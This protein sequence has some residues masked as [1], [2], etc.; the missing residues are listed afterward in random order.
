MN[1][2]RQRLLLLYNLLFLFGLC[3]SP[4]IAQSAQ[5][6]HPSAILEIDSNTKGFL[7]P[8]MT[9][10]ERNAISDPAPGLIIFNYTTQRINFF[11]GDIWKQ[12]DRQTQTLEEGSQNISVTVSFTYAN[13][14]NYMVNSPAYDAIEVV[15]TNVGEV[16]LAAYPA[17]S[18]ITLSGVTNGV[19]ITA[20]IGGGEVNP[21][22]SMTLTYTLTGTPT[23][24]GTLTADYTKD[25]G[26]AINHI[27]VDPQENITHNGQTYLSVRTQ[28]G[29]TWLDRNLGAANVGDVGDYYQWGRATDGHEKSDSGITTTLATS[30]TPGHDDFISS[31]GDWRNPLNADLWQGVDGTNNPCPSGYRLPT[32]TDWETEYNSWPSRST[33]N[34]KASALNL[35]IT[36]NRRG[37]DGNIINNNN[38]FFYWSSEVGK[39]IRKGVHAPYNVSYW[40]VAMAKTEGIPVRCIKD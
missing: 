3:S 32:R 24:S 39:V 29:Q 28:P 10:A 6:T 17:I 33:A 5:K 13:K 8:R 12:I 11:A 40:T 36:G 14:A 35:D 30:D 23:T 25:W 26:S 16:A 22:N 7:P 15:L 27:A 38:G 4:L 34:A 31:S 19:S 20:A 2:T 9:T 21:G 18:D 37:N 1:A